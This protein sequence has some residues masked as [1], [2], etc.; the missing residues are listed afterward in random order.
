MA[1][2][3]MFLFRVEGWEKNAV[4]DTCFFGASF[5]GPQK[6]DNQCVVESFCHARSCSKIGLHKIACFMAQQT[7]LSLGFRVGKQVFFEVIII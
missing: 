2:N 7:N 5:L 4:V 3:N 6:L 1:S